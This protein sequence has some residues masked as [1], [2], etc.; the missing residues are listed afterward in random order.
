[1]ALRPD[2]WD[3]MGLLSLGLNNGY[4]S[5]HRKERGETSPPFHREIF[6]WI[7]I[8]GPDREMKKITG[9]GTC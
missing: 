8:E 2:L 6:G 4:T 9:T 3:S 1:M 5:V 7:K